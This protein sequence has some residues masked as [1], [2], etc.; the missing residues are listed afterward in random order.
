MALVQRTIN[1]CDVCGHEWIPRSA[2]ERCGNRNCRSTK[3]ND[4]NANAAKARERSKLTLAMTT[5]TP[6]VPSVTGPAKMD[7]LQNI[8]AGRLTPAA[9]FQA[10]VTSD[11]FSP[12][13]VVCEA[14]MREFKGKWACADLSCGKYGVEQRLR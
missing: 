8:C 6:S 4:L 1:Q 3:W 13:C 7:T 11:R 9:P 12:P 14:P 2:G 10:E 5:M